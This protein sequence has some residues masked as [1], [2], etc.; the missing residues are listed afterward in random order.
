MK[1]NEK[2]SLFDRVSKRHIPLLNLLK[3]QKVAED[4][5]YYE[6]PSIE[7]ELP[8]EIKSVWDALGVPEEIRRTIQSLEP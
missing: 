5:P 8:D 6:N 3:A 4:I 2:N 7:D 1:K